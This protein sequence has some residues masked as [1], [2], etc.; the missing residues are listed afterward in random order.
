MRKPLHKRTLPGRSRIHGWG[1]FAATKIVGGDVIDESPVVILDEEPS[2]Q[3]AHWCYE[4]DRGYALV[5]GDGVLCNS[6]DDFNARFEFD[7][8][9]GIVRLVALRDIPPDIEITLDYEYT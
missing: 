9:R 3:I 7:W 5:L 2:D 8:Q 1:L 4:T 6:A